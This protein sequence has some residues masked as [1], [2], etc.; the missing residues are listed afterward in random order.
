MIMKFFDWLESRTGFCTLL[1]AVGNRRWVKTLMDM[2]MWPGILFFLCAVQCITGFIL[3]MHYSPSTQTAYESVFHIQYSLWGG[4]LLRGIHHHSAQV[5]M[6]VAMIYVIRF[7]LFGM[8]RKPRELT[9]WLSMLI[10]FFGLAA[11]LTGDLL[12]WTQNAY[13]ATLVRVKY[14]TQIPFVGQMLYELAC[15]GSGINNLTLTHFFALHVGVFAAGTIVLLILHA[16]CDART[17]RKILDEQLASGELKVPAQTAASCGGCRSTGIARWW[18]CQAAVNALGCCV[19]MG[20]VLALCFQNLGEYREAKKLSALKAAPAVE[21]PANAPAAETAPVEAPAAVEAA[22]AP[23]AGNDA[24]AVVEAVQP[25]QAEP[26][27]APAP[28]EPAQAP[29]PAPV[30]PAPAPAPVPVEPAPAP[31]PAPAEPAPAPAAEETLE[32][33]VV[34][35][36]APTP[37]ADAAPAAP[38]P[39]VNAETAAPAEAPAVGSAVTEET[40]A[41]AE[42]AEAEEAEEAM[43]VPSVVKPGLY[44]GAELGPPAD[45]SPM[46]S[47]ET[48]RP[49]WTLRCLYEYAL[50]FSSKCP[51]FILI[52]CIPGAVVVIFF[53][54]PFI[55]RIRG[56]HVFNVAFFAVIALALIYLTFA[57]YDR[58][59]K[60]EAYQTAMKSE[61]QRAMDVY[62]AIQEFGGI[63]KSGALSMISGTAPAASDA[64]VVIP[65]GPEVFKKHCASCHPYAPADETVTG[66]DIFRMETPCAPNLWGYGTRDWIAGWMDKN[67]VGTKDY[68]GYENSAFEEMKTVAESLFNQMDP[69]SPLSEDYSDED[70]AKMRAE[71]DSIIELLT[72]EASLTQPRTASVEAVELR[73]LR[74]K[75]DGKNLRK[76][77]DRDGNEVKEVLQ[78]T[79]DGVNPDG[80]AAYSKSCLKCH[81][82]YDYPKQPGHSGPDLT[83]YASKEWTKRVIEDASK[84]YDKNTMTIFHAEPEGSANNLMTPLEIEVVAAWLTEGNL[85]KEDAPAESAE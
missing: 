47:S 60:N 34:E 59:A 65:T 31:A 73:K 12:P 48:V 69:N 8:Y 78:Y 80:L 57:S 5:F 54:M 76:I 75:S 51:E 84:F 66:D 53:L 17:E 11:C 77:E 82:F 7:I 41:P 26:A 85:K 72:A 56:G 18:S 55:A 68:I 45:T 79:I 63:R 1:K 10:F 71:L 32:I 15:G 40:A 38:A 70:R 13:G 6:A 50:L 30:E 23:A 22:P 24:N 25:A 28:V 67:R 43:A 37:A 81:Q 33:E 35:E 19:A 21:A 46:A 2:K 39:E 14:L 36:A 74:W 52:F 9:F 62:S 4:W 64:E 27:P 49:E 44:L 29:A 3:W 58:D 20:I 16:I 42:E 83:A 61:R